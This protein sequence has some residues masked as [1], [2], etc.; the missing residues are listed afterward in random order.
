MSSREN[1]D[2]SKF[3]DELSE[4]LHRDRSLS[5][6]LSTSEVTEEEIE[7]ETISC[8]FEYL[9]LR[10]CPS[11]LT[12]AL[13][14]KTADGVLSSDISGFYDMEQSESGAP[15]L[16]A[17]KLAR[18]IFRHL[19]A[20]C[21]AVREDLPGLSVVD[22]LAFSIHTIK[23][24]RLSMEDRHVTLTPFNALFGLPDVP[25]QSFFAIYDGHGGVE[26]ARYAATHLHV[27]IVRNPHFRDDVGLA[28]REAFQQTDDSYCARSR[29][30]GHRSGTTAIV[31][32]VCMS[33]LHIA[34]CGDS[35]LILVRDNSRPVSVINPHRPDRTDERRRIESAG[36]DVKWFG[37]WR[38]DG[39][40]SVS[41]AIGDRCY[42]PYVTAE[43]DVISMELTPSD[44]YM[45][46]ACDGLWDVVKPSEIP[47]LVSKEMRATG[48]R[49]AVASKLVDHARALGSADNIS[50]IVVFFDEFRGGDGVAAAT[51]PSVFARRLGSH[52]PRS[53]P[54]SLSLPEGAPPHAGDSRRTR[55]FSSVS[56]LS[57][58]HQ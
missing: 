23:N 33:A 35:Q 47:R 27:N 10:D 46:M 31:A 40:L 26:A 22:G 2:F 21:D 36:G 18:A 24:T 55:N 45:V 49:S 34:W 53:R 43:P 13:A 41:R 15:L 56:P 37:T 28:L 19:R 20:S 39:L 11:C 12:A 38:V 29:R 32:M 8:V 4:S 1:D 17:R 16:S 7:G 5:F 58:K 44:S 14:R 48:D 30:E 52:G 57:C 50:A 9:L 25:S 3:L 6:R 51:T 54:N 42:K